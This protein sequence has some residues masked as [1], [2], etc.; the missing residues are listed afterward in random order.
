ML[1]CDL[2]LSLTNCSCKLFLRSSCPT[3]CGN[4][5]LYHV[6]Y[7]NFFFF[8]VE[9]KFNKHE[10]YNIIKRWAYVH[11]RF[12]TRCSGIWG[13]KVGI[14]ELVILG[15]AV[16]NR[17]GRFEYST[18]SAVLMKTESIR[19]GPFDASDRPA[20]SGIKN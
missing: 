20:R 4:S 7:S 18:G 1:R 13:S 5:N 10:L 14:W 12:F 19:P 6:K 9:N 11:I 17:T 16:Q 15:K 2:D 3:R 8:F